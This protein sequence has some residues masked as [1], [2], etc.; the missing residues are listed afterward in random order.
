MK[1]NKKIIFKKNISKKEIEDLCK[2]KSENWD[3]DLKSQINW[4][5]ENS[6]E[7]YLI[8]T[9]M[10]IKKKVAFLRIRK[11]EIF[12]NS[13]PLKCSFITEVC[14]SNKFKSMGIGRKIMFEANKY[15]ISQKEI[16]YLLCFKDKD[17]FYKKCK[18]IS[19]SNINFRSKSFE[20]FLRNKQKSC[21]FFNFKQKITLPQLNNITIEVK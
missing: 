1:L 2:I 14:V 18:W 7:D 20:S 10:N 19:L 8:I 6:D 16:G 13:K 17:E 12:I 4:W 5:K 11:R 15:L 21:F 3:Y 9:L